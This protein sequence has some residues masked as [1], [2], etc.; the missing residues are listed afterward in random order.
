MRPFKK[1]TIRDKE[2]IQRFTMESGRMTA[3]MLF[4][5]ICGW[6]HITNMSYAIIEDMLVMRGN[7]NN[8]FI[9]SLP[10]GRGNLRF[11]LMQMMEEAE[12][13]GARC[14]IFGIPE[15]RIEEVERAMPKHFEFY[16]EESNSDYIYKRENL[17]SL[18][19]KKMQ[20]KRNHI[21]KFH[22]SYPNAQFVELT[23]AYVP[24]CK[25][26][27]IEWNKTHSEDGSYISKADELT[28]TNFILDN[29]RLLGLCG[30]VLLVDENVAAFTIGGPINNSTF[31]ICVEKADAR[32]D[33]AYT[34]INN[35]FAASLPEK[36]VYINRE[37][38]MGIE[39]LRQAK[40]SYQPEKLLKKYVA[41][42]RMSFGQ[43]IFYNN[44]RMVPP[45]S[46]STFKLKSSL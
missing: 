38:D 5:N 28:F 26:L 40:Q 11:V 4:A 21:N 27:E 37:E 6:Q 32:Y 25:Q 7:M 41:V 36:F 12:N 9:Y 3:D 10:I 43:S 29:F 42:P 46:N 2:A 18:A 14:R 8:S 20:A 30:G 35:L 23:E 16:A 15:E 17:V 31:D 22:R 44:E 34:V 1:L 39:G 24:A 19:G 13:F 45:P 33:G